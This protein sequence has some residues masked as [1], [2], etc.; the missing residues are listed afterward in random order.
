M[1]L[2][3]LIKTKLIKEAIL[4]NLIKLKLLTKHLVALPMRQRDEKLINGLKARKNL[5]T[6]TINQRSMTPM[7][8]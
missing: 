3:T 4:N 2:L 6:M 8:S 1:T 5:K 7:T